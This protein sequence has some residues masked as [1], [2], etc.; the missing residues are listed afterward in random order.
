[1]NNLNAMKRISSLS[2]ALILA[3][4]L[5]AQQT[6]SLKDPRDGKTY[7]T[8]EI[9]N[10][11]WMAENLAYKH[12]SGNYWAYDNNNG[13]VM[14]KYGYLYDWQ[15]AMNVCPTGWHLPNDDEWTQLIDFVGRHAATKLKAKSGWTLHGNGIDKY[16]FSALPGGYRNLGGK[17][18]MFGHH[19][20]WWSST[21]H[22]T[23]YN[24]WYL[25]IAT[26]IHETRYYNHKGWG[27]SVRCVRD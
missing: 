13:N 6:G 11:V 8:V 19:G 3:I 18:N 17:F 24:A 23:D 26:S 27:F 10:Q 16:G 25:G 9:G 1:M 2:I 14:A 22:T 5:N 4:N 12:S 20:Y 15:T 7:K 21:E